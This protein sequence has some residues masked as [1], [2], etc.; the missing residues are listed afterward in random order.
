MIDVKREI[1]KEEYDKAQAEGAESLISSD[2]IIGYGVSC[3]RVYEE[4]GK[5]YLTYW[6]GNSCD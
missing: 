5:F 4:D 1:S 2:I 6:R 3:A